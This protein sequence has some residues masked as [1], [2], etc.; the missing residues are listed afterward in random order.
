MLRE[1]KGVHQVPGEP[2]RRWFAG[3]VDDPPSKP[4]GYCREWLEEEAS[5]E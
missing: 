1:S 3:K 4:M 2:R 5:D